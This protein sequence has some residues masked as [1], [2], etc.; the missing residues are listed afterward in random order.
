MAGPSVRR[1]GALLAAM[2]LLSRL[3][4]YL[5][6]AVVAAAIGASGAAD[7]FF[8]A[9]RI[10]DLVFAL[11]AAGS[12]SAGLVPVIAALRGA[13]EEE[14]A[15]RVAWSV[16]TAVVA[17]S[18]V[19]AALGILC[20]GLLTPAATPGFSTAAMEETAALTRILFLS[21]PLLAASAVA[22]AL[23]VARER[24]FVQAAAPLLY[25]A[26]A[27][28]AAVIAAAVAGDA[29]LVAWGVV[30]GAG[31]H[32]AVHLLALR[33][34]GVA[35][36]PRLEMG[37]PE[38]RRAVRLLLPRAA[39]IG[40]AQLMA[41]AA[42][43]VASGG[44]AGTVSAY[45]VALSV[46]ALPVALIGTSI[47]S[48]LLPRVARLRG[49]GDHVAAD[50]EA[51]QAFAAV[52]PLLAAAA[53]GAALYA[54]EIAAVVLP[55]AAEAARGAM[56]A[57]LPQIAPGFLL[58]GLMAVAVRLRFAAGDGRSPLIAAAWASAAAVG[59]AMVA[60][61][62]NAGLVYSASAAVQFALLLRGGGLGADIVLPPAAR[63]P[64]AVALALTAAPAA[65]ALLLGLP[66]PLLPAA[67]AAGAGPLLLLRRLR[68]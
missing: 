10:P 9:F 31:A 58:H 55:A 23:L 28:A 19:A 56:A 27:I 47:G 13:G 66:R 49:A 21:P 65:L 11:T 36:R 53:V 51:A 26:A 2:S 14:R 1:T 5:R 3:S 62:A 8:A 34:A 4:G 22:A 45:S 15:D 48:A 37:D 38:V 7:P 40:A 57:V 12:L 35:L 32:L 59:V 41:A 42:V 39:A 17:A 16:G 6:I 46:A 61:P 52:T 63:R 54:P 68:G 60:A 67:I 25:N 24:F 44:P 18:A 43:A 50:R 20:A 33:R 64:A 29:S 30:A